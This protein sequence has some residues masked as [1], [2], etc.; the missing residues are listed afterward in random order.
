M[1]TV[2]RLG[3]LITTLVIFLIIATFTGL[4]WEE[5]TIYLAIALTAINAQHLILEFKPNH[6][7]IGGAIWAAGLIV[8]PAIV[9]PRWA[10]IFAIMVVVNF[11]MA[12][13]SSTIK[14]DPEMDRQLKEAQ[15]KWREAKERK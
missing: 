5:S 1:T 7:L 6:S 13:T 8:Y 10:G 2:Q 9:G 15:A 11:M 12:L 3:N 14:R 4:S